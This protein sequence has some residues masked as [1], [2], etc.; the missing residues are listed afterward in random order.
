[1]YVYIQ[2]EVNWYTVGFYR[3]DGEWVAESDHA[4]REA[5]GERVAYLNGGGK[6]PTTVHAQL[7]QRSIYSDG[8]AGDPI[9]RY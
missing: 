4:T 9:F 5:A 2:S 3:P 1:M 7:P 8:R 6:Q